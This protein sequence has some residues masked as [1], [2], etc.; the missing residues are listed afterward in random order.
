L[1]S[2]R[3]AETNRDTHLTRDRYF[4]G[5]DEDTNKEHRYTAIKTGHRYN[6]RIQK[7]L[8]HRDN[9]RHRQNDEYNY[10]CP[11]YIE[12][13]FVSAIVPKNVFAFSS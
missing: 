11:T 7:Q 4:T 9:Q 1:T 5:R 6:Y 10:A 8:G 3:K 12:I 13:R 2:T